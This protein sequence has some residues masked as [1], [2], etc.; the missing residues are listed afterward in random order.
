MQSARFAL[1]VVLASRV[2]LARNRV[3]VAPRRWLLAICNLALLL[4]RGRRRLAIGIVDV[5]RF[6][7]ANMRAASHKVGLILLAVWLCAIAWREQRLKCAV[8]ALPVAAQEQAYRRAYDE[9]AT[10]CAAQP[11]LE[12][13]CRE[14]AEFI[15]RLPQCS[16]DCRTLTRRFVPI[17]TK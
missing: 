13:H 6:A 5:T 7:R 4:A 2:Q 16:D 10:T 12:S 8:S 9:L 11:E 17:A 14:E 15:R 3:R 1:Y